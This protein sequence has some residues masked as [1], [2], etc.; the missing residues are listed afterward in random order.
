MDTGNVSAVISATAGI[1]GELIGKSVGADKEWLIDPSRR[2]KDTEYLAIIVVFH[3]DRL[4]NGCCM[5]PMTTVLRTANLRV[6]MAKETSR[7]QKSLNFS[8]WTSMSSGIK[9]PS[10]AMPMKRTQA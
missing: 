10:C 3:L 2:R 7:Q 6:A 9:N 8:R 4:A 5:S 1:S